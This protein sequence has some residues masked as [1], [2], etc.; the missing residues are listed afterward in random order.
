MV[1]KERIIYDHVSHVLFTSHAVNYILIHIQLSI[2]FH[3][4]YNYVQTFCENS[5]NLTCKKP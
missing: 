1:F 4:K 5:N 2:Y 3:L